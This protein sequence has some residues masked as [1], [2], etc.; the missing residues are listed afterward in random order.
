MSSF[1][2]VRSNRVIHWIRASA[3]VCAAAFVAPG[4]ST[5]PRP[6][7]TIAPQSPCTIVATGPASAETISIAAAAPVDP[8]HVPSPAN[9][10]ER[11]VFAQ[12]YE[13]LVDVDCEGRAYPGLAKSWTLD[14]SRTRITLTIRDDARFWDGKAVVASD[15]VTAW[16]ATGGQLTEAS[17]LA[18]RVAN[19]TT[20][21]DDHTL[22]VSL[23]DTAWR[24]LA[25]PALAVY[26][27][28]SGPGWAG[29]TSRY[30]VES[31]SSRGGLLLAPAWKSSDPQLSVRP[32]PTSDARD[33][34][35]RG[36]DVLVTDDPLTINYAASRPNLAAVP[37][38]WSRTYVVAIPHVA[39]A[40]TGTLRPMLGDSATAF[41]ASLAR[42]AVRVEARGADTP[43]WWAD[44][45]ACASPGPRGAAPR[46]SEQR[47]LRIAY[48]AADRVAR[49][50]AERIVA[51]DSR[52]TATPLAAGAFARALHD[53]GQ[54]AYVIAV[55]RASLDPCYDAARLVASA[56]WLLAN[57]A[58]SPSAP[59]T[60]I[61]L[62]DTRDR[63]IVNR[64]RVSAT[65]DWD[66]TLRFGG[67]PRTP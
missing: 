29:G 32:L 62:V 54:P 43:N 40:D 67:T 24:V 33:A 8:A 42:D 28:Q 12:L 4:C 51:L 25:D 50:L 48:D 58:G 11:F 61:P 17:Q 2:R 31:E 35:D 34:I 26:Q 9:G 13:T 14:A 45:Q 30:R 7:T 44:V 3:F 66:G 20:I 49:R 21:V 10:A 19:G 52:A 38:P 1:R 57:D 23:P 5:T 6:A 18:L 27:P 41:R 55:P 47:P 60:I 53:G 22:I 65:I 37:L 39:P 59:P 15:V 46:T 64:D 36:I 63:A 56:P 16:H